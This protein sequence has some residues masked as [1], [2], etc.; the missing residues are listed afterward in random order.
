MVGW[1]YT[2]MLLV[3]AGFLALQAVRHSGWYKQR[4]YRELLE[5][6]AEQQLYAASALAQ[7]GAQPQLLAALHAESDHA[8]KMAQRALEFVWFNAAGAKA[9]ALLESA[10]AASQR[11]HYHEALAIL[12]ELT[13]RFPKFAEGWNRRAAVHWELG[14][15]AQSQADCERALALNPQHYGAW[16]GIGLCQLRNGD[17]AGACRSLRAALKILPHD[18]AT[19]QSLHRCESLMEPDRAPDAPPRPPEIR[20]EVI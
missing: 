3:C 7:L 18:P 1:F 11:E 5:G 17:I 14:D 6:G 19:R 13:T 8:R 16:Q 20:G 15:F 2:S 9:Y 10:Y 4:L 12:D